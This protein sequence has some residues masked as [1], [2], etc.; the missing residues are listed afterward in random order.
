MKAQIQPHFIFN[1]L[2]SVSAL[3]EDDKIKAQEVLNNLSS[4]LRQSFKNERNSLKTVS[5]EIH[6]LEDYMS[7][8][9]TR[10]DND[11]FFK[12]KIQK[13]TL[14]KKIPSFVLQPLV[15]NSIKHGF[16]ERH[17]KLL[18]IIELF[19]ENEYIHILVSNNGK[20]IQTS[21]GKRRF[22]KGTALINIRKRLENLYGDNFYFHVK[23]KKDESG[24]VSKIIIPELVKKSFDKRSSLKL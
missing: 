12:T 17:P 19:F 23:N 22:A 2:N 24:V 16:S 14:N 8:I 21:I 11:F 1:T 13:Q 6:F 15:E 4:F 9:K 20:P 5:E 18:V 3:V 7:L 10:F